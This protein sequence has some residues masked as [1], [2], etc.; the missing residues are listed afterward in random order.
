MAARV[1]ILP[2]RTVAFHV[3]TDDASGKN[4]F[5]AIAADDAGVRRIS[6]V[7]CSCDWNGRTLRGLAIADAVNFGE[8]LVLRGC[9]SWIRRRIHC[10]FCTM[11]LLTGKLARRG[12]R[13]FIPPGC[14]KDWLIVGS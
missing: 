8:S 7:P 4:E 13:L 9:A 6:N 14:T 10:G 1:A 2:N 11:R 3:N 12:E 5:V